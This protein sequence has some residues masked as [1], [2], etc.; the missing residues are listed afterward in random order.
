MS[1]NQRRISLQRQ[2]G[3]LVMV[4]VLL[5]LLVGTVCTALIGLFS[6]SETATINS[7]RAD[8]AYYVAE[9]GFEETA[10]LLLTP[11]LTGANNRI[12]CAAITGTSALTNTD[13]GAGTF[14]ATTV[15]GSPVY[16]NTTLSGALNSSATTVSVASTTGF[17]AA[18]RIRID[19]EILNYGAISGNSFIGVQR[20]VNTTYSAPHVT[21]TPVVQ[22]QCNVN[23]TAGIPSLTAPLSQR[24]LQQSWQLQEGWAGGVLSGANYVFTHWNRP[25]EAAWS[26]D[27]V[28]NSSAAT[29][30]SVSMLSNGDG[31][32]VGNVVGKAFTILHWTGTTWDLVSAPTACS[33][34]NLAGISA[35][36]HNEAWAVG[37]A[38][39]ST[40]NC[41]SPGGSRVYDVAYWNGTTWALLTPSTTPSVPADSG[42]NQDLNAVHVIDT[43]HSGAG[44]LGFAVGNGGAI[45]QYNGSNWINDTSP[46][47]N[48]LYGV[49]V[50]SAT[51]AWAVG[52]AGTII[53]WNGSTWS[54][55]SSPTSTQ[56][57]SIAM[58]DYTQSGSAQTGWA[59]G[60]SGVAI[61]YNGSTWTTSSTGSS[62]NLY[63]VALF[64]TSPDQDVWAVGAAGTMLHY[65]G[66]AWAAVTSNVSTDLNA[67]SLIPPQQYG[68]AESEIF[69]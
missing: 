60:N 9:A 26:A 64:T 25:T 62:A 46:T 30:N 18:G 55:V 66:S 3:Y 32:A 2:H 37:P 68:F 69:P 23:V 43:T 24:T 10:R 51:Q 15:A 21:A 16:A 61:Y 67:I 59:V 45:L 63:D 41:N 34:Q 53:K 29:I 31:W 22:Y 7:L 8:Q 65:N 42:S 54:T 58:L 35:V 48:N 1:Y 13:A 50:V 5:I 38:T 33:T 11:N 57:N 14:T 19:N 47:T 27:L 12:A 56:L 28:A 49:Y 52:A 17:S 39:K 6:G 20:G 36:Y 44:T 4:A 40:G